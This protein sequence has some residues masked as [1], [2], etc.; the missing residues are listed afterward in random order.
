MSSFG[1][2]YVNNNIKKSQK[3][4]NESQSILY[5]VYLYN[6]KSNDIFIGST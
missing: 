3:I 6:R 5:K 2:T 1:S 4:M